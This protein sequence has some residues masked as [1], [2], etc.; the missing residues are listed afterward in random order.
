MPSGITA[1]P[2]RIGLALSGG[3][4]RAAVFHLGVLRHLAGDGRLEHITQLSTVSGGSLV[5]GAVFARAGG[6][7][8]SS[9]EFLDSVYPSVRETLVSGDLLSFKALGPIDI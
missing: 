6:R 8:P 5:A 2:P 9:T 7:W 1:N 3:G 4:V